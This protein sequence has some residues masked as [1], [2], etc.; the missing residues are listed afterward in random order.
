MKKESLK[1]MLEMKYIV[2]KIKDIE[3]LLT[4]KEIRQLK[5]MIQKIITLRT[6]EKEDREKLEREFL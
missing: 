2:L 6:I 1:D 5:F 4:L 3:E